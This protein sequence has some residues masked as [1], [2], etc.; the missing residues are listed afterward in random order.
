MSKRASGGTLSAFLILAAI[1][2]FAV[3]AYLGTQSG[4]DA[5]PSAASTDPPGTDTPDGDSTGAPSDGDE[6]DEDGEDEPSGGSGASL[7]LSQSTAGANATIEY[8]LTLDSGEAGVL[9]QMQRNVDGAGWENFPIDA[10]ETDDNGQI[11]GNVQSSR[12]GQNAFRMIGVN[13]DS[14]VSSEAVVTIE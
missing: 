2:G 4:D 8:T 9:M 13:D 7:E 1:V 5:E 11:S 10:R 3:G 12:P 14:I 6:Q